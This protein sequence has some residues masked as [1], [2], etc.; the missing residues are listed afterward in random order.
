MARV[1]LVAALGLAAGC[2]SMNNSCSSCE[3]SF[4][5]RLT[6]L[7]RHRSTPTEVVGAPF[8]GP[9]IGE[10]SPF[11]G[12]G[13]QPMPF[14]PSGPQPFP[15]SALPLPQSSP[16]PLIPAPTPTYPIEAQ[17]MPYQR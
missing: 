15:P 1:A 16:P 13:C 2:S 17:R 9:L 3:P 6:G 7:F 4:T 10:P 5:S 8:D 12:P 14:P 11:E